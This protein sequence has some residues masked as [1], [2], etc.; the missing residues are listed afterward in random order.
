ML[1]YRAARCSTRR[2]STI[3]VMISLC[4]GS[5]LCSS[6]L[7]SGVRGS[8]SRLLIICSVIDFFRKSRLALRSSLE[9]SVSLI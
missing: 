2:L 6:E 9:R 5:G 3:L 1:S 7:D 4:M 8:S